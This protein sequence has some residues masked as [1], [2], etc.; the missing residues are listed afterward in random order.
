[1][2][3]NNL[4]IAWRNLMKDRQ[5]TFLNLLGLSTGLACTLLIYLWIHDEYQFDKFHE[6]D[7][8]LYQLME[9]RKGTGQ[10]FIAD[11][12]SGILSETI[13]VQNPEVE[14]AAA[15]APASWF[16]KFT[17]S[18]DDKNLKAT[19]QYV[20]KDYLNIFSF[21]LIDGNPANVLSDKSNIVISDELAKKLFNRTDHLIGKKIL[22]Q[23]DKTFFVSGVIEKVP[24]HSSEQFD[25]LLS[26]EYYQEIQPWVTSWGNTGPHNFVLL[27]KGTDLDAFNKRIA[28]VI[29]KSSGDTSRT[30]FA[31]RFSDNY[32][33]NSFDHGNRI[34]GRIVNVKLFAFIALFILGIACINFMNLSTAKASRRLKEVGIKKVVGA[35]RNQLVFQFLGESILLTLLAVIIAICLTLFL[36]PKF[37]QITGKEISLQFDWDLIGGLAG[38][39]LLTGFVSG[40]YPALYLAG[41]NPILILKGKMRS[42]VGELWAR[43]GLVIFQF[44]ISIF[45]IVGVLV[46]YKQILFIQSKDLGYKKDHIIRM[47]CEGKLVAREEDFIE[48]LKKVQG[49]ADASFTYNVMIGRNYGNN[50][51]G[52]EG[53]NPN[54]YVYFEGFGGG[55]D[56]IETLGMKMAE[57][58]SFSKKFGDES[59]KII[60]N[61]EAVRTM[62]IK[63]PVGKNITLFGNNQQIVGVIKDFH[64]ESLRETV[65]PLYLKLI[66]QDSSPWNK[67][68]I[69]VQAGQEKETVERI[70]AFYE[71][72]NPGFPFDFHF[73]DDLYEKQYSAELRVSIL[74][75]YFAG[76]A[77][78]ISCLGLFG[79][80]AF[81]A[82]K[83]QKEIGIRKVI[84][85]SVI[86]VVMMLS[87][88][89]F[90][91]VL[92]AILIAIP[93]SAWAMNLW[94]NGFAYRISIG[95]MIFVIAACSVILITLITIS[96]QSLKAAVRN[97]VT[98]L[99]SE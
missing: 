31:M 84:G 71:R 56:F 63:N 97:P 50:G 67:L 45:M 39:T 36:L 80:T 92:I 47:D 66:K 70:K 90:K 18:V 14:Y 32:L 6:K 82:Q 4:K 29:Q 91:Q 77:I 58:R 37:N 88:D 86:D 44:T 55:Y 68:M 69:R 73:L 54:E 27:K 9:H 74:S 85:A 30:A 94:L 49:V 95:S 5:F 12:S 7:A 89:L 43:R 23:H 38:I 59:D 64:F 35:R 34:G 22:F 19:G 25:F 81:T 57:G 3:K 75:K 17:L 83:R 10:V 40:S 93:V 20:G 16:Q 51:I 76:L 26:F 62:G 96:F 46:I 15:E 21:K 79:L 61:E 72:Y 11:E 41:F 13:A 24:V 65:K 98:S 99:R 42:S 28:N 53:K 48:Q 2:F 52:W 33:Q 87:K 78:L 60:V 8:R 1:M